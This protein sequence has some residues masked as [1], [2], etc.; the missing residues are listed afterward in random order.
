[1]RINSDSLNKNSF[2]ISA[3]VK[4]MDSKQGGIFEKTIGERV[5]SQ[6]LLF[7]E[8]GRYYFRIATPQGIRSISY[9]LS[10]HKW[11]H[12][13]GVYNGSAIK[14]YQNGIL[15]NST[16]AGNILTGL[17]PAYIGKLG[18][19]I[20]PLR[21]KIDEVIFHDRALSQKEIILLS[22]LQAEKSINSELKI[23][24]KGV[25]PD[26][27]LYAYK[28]LGADGGGN[29][30]DVISGIE[31]AV[32]PN[33]DFNFNDSVD[34]ISMSLG[35]PGTPDD[36]VSKAADNAVSKGV[37]VVVAAGNSGPSKETIGSPGMARKVITVG[38]INKSYSLAYFSS[39]GPVLWGGQGLIKP[40]ILAPGVAIYSTTPEGKYEAFS[41]TSMA[42]PHVAGIAALM[43][44]AHKDWAPEEIKMALKGNA[45]NVESLS[46]NEQ[47]NGIMNGWA[48]VYSQK[49]SKVFLS[50]SKKKG[51][52]E[53][54]AELPKEFTAENIALYYSEGYGEKEW[55]EMILEEKDLKKGKL[56]KSIDAF[57][58]KDGPY[59]F[60]IKTREGSSFGQDDAIIF[61]DNL[62][63]SGIGNYEIYRPGEINKIYLNIEALE[64]TY[65]DFK[66]YIIEYSLNNSNLEWK[67]QGLMLCEPG[68]EGISYE[69]VGNDLCERR[70]GYERFFI[71]NT[72]EIASG[73]YNLR[74]RVNYTHSQV[75]EQISYIYFDKDLKEGWPQR[76]YAGNYSTHAGDIVP[77]VFDLDKDGDQEIIINKGRNGYDPYMTLVVYHGNGSIYWERT[78]GEEF[79]N[80]S[81]GTSLNVLPTI[82]D[83]D[84]DKS[85]D[86]VVMLADYTKASAEG[87]RVYAVNATGSIKPGYPITVAND[88]LPQIVVADLDGDKSDEIIIQT[89]FLSNSAYPEEIII[90]SNKSIKNRWNLPYGNLGNDEM[91]PTIGNFD[92]D[93]DLEIVS[94]RTIGWPPTTDY[95]QGYTNLLFGRT[96]TKGAIY[97]YN[98]DG[99][100]VEGWPLAMG[101]PT[102][103][104]ATPSIGD[105]DGDGTSEIIASYINYSTGTYVT[106]Y[107]RNGEIVEGFPFLIEL[108]D[109]PPY[110]VKVI[111]SPEKSFTLNDL[112]GDRKLEIIFTTSGSYEIGYPVYVLYSNG[113]LMS[114][115]PNAAEGGAYKNYAPTIAD[116]DGDGNL[117]ILATAG[118]VF[119]IARYDPYRD[120]LNLSLEGGIWAWHLNG[121]RIMGY[122]KGL[123]YN[124]F[125]PP[126]IADVDGDGLMDLIGSSAY[127]Y[128][129]IRMEPKGYGSLHVWET[130][131]T[132]PLSHEQW[133]MFRKDAGR[134][135]CYECEN[136]DFEGTTQ[137]RE[138]QDVEEEFTIKKGERVKLIF[139]ET[140]NLT[141]IKK[142]PALMNNII[143][144]QNKVSINTER[145]PELNKS[146]ELTFK[147][148]RVNEPYILYNN[149]SCPAE[150]CTSQYNSSSRILILN[151][152]HFSTFEVI[153]S[154]ICGDGICQA[155]IEESCSSCSLDCGECLSIGDSPPSSG[156]G[157]RS[158][159]RSGELC[160]PNEKC[161]LGACID[162]IQVKECRDLNNC[163]GSLV[164]QENLGCNIFFEPL[165]EEIEGDSKQE[166][167][168]VLE[169]WGEIEEKP[170]MLN[171]IKIG[172]AVGIV[173]LIAI[174][175]IIYIKRKQSP[176]IYQNDAEE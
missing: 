165:S 65:K 69:M 94:L 86:I 123:H 1:M 152:N 50:I 172:I 157:S 142:N 7:I 11:E 60:R 156:R 49:P 175:L 42:T 19:G 84:G 76:I 171:Y 162:E 2:T 115:W 137:L 122:P 53:I 35:G 81:F 25:A 62:N 118:S 96:T 80:G 28:V 117:D 163:E 129:L 103:F 64:H 66:N 72:S 39:R 73:I 85:P 135:A 16:K 56:S 138:S 43:K 170:N 23:G 132:Y 95:W 40:D 139:K 27:I 114:G 79:L 93:D 15:V 99:S 113:T 48:S 110:T 108:I 55:A 133:G 158:S 45:I 3:W 74:L 70:R 63:I 20:Y 67:T 147:D 17:G 92:S 136:K 116:V 14:L 52:L 98:L 97:V 107:K 111:R 18:G 8:N 120:K 140:V 112:D 161:T 155:A 168:T 159:S 12:L 46:P 68:G 87:G 143:L 153:E 4:P 26:S 173:M 38:A 104:F 166:D 90:I 125:A 78:L 160:I 167:T 176:S 131:V 34:I 141:R 146:A 13:A 24:I 5:N 36:P 150:I 130:N 154:P 102:G 145:V 121:T 32:D 151:V 91:V 54:S 88:R 21:G 61:I 47:G 57:K 134:T 22:D 101:G 77:I 174:I 58:L 100:I 149:Q 106:A 164:T 37:I 169:G 127:D 89:N 51:D 126:T 128:D 30:E 59:A 148:V 6:Y 82:G 105:L 119:P 71:W 33:N 75:E 31:R 44:Q 41:G 10:S 109:L 29:F 144:S 83:L 9:P 124:S